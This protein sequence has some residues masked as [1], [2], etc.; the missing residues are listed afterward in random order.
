MARPK[1]QITANHYKPLEGKHKV[2]ADGESMMIG[3]AS[4]KRTVL[5]SSA[6]PCKETI[7][8]SEALDEMDSLRTQ[9]Q[10]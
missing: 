4:F 5:K 10:S 3:N 2:S 8:L 9:E 7:E 6:T 1:K